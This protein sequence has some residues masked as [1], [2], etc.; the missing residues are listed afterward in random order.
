MALPLPIGRLLADLALIYQ[1]GNGMASLKTFYKAKV[2]S[3]GIPACFT[4]VRFN[5]HAARQSQ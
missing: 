4:N 1:F 3:S 2:G 5:L